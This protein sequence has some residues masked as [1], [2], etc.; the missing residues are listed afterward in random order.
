MKQRDEA[1]RL[2]VV[3]SEKAQ[4]AMYDSGKMKADRDQLE[5]QLQNAIQ[6]EKLLQDR[7]DF[8]KEKVDT[9][10][11]SIKNLHAESGHFREYHEELCSKYEKQDEKHYKEI[12]SLEEEIQTLR[13]TIQNLKTHTSPSSQSSEK[14]DAFIAP[15]VPES[16]AS[17]EEAAQDDSVSRVT[18]SIVFK[19]KTPNRLGYM[20][21]PRKLTFSTPFKIEQFK[22]KATQSSSSSDDRGNTKTSGGALL[23]RLADEVGSD[24]SEPNN[25]VPAGTRKRAY[26]LM[27][28]P[29]PAYDEKQTLSGP[30]HPADNEDDMGPN[31]NLFGNSSRTK[32]ALGN[33]DREEDWTAED[34]RAAIAHLYEMAKGI[35]FNLHK[36]SIG[37]NVPDELLHIQEPEIW[38]LLNSLV[39][40]DR[41]EAAAH[42]RFL[43]MTEQY[44]PYV[45]Q[46]VMLDYIF[47]TIMT[48][49][50][51]LGFS[52]DMDKQL[53]ALQS[54]IVT[55]ANVNQRSSN[56]SRQRTIEEHAQ[57]I[58]S[59][60][61]QKD[62]RK[63]RSSLVD[64]HA[65]VLTNVLTPLQNS[66]VPDEMALKA[67]RILIRG[68]YN[69]S[70]R[71]WSSGMTL[72]YF[73]PETG[74]KFLVATMEAKNGSVL[75]SSAE[76]LQ[77]SQYRISLVIGPTLTL[78]DDRESSLLRTYGIRKA[79]V[80]VMK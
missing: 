35:V 64:H 32:N 34:V 23:H 27:P 15:S 29:F 71:I 50:I 1:I 43:L 72:H 10:K 22:D 26:S 51:F 4:H 45:I 37:P 41:P 39:Y 44:R 73:F 58:K 47:K 24:S 66:T 25:Q 59:I 55:F 11:E 17:V 61:D 67:M 78:R 49:D 57:L 60:G 53:R 54:Q 8:S 63:F 16:T 12:R 42:T 75:G 19:G 21:N 3:D 79:Q 2:R 14:A 70:M 20:S 80:L 38:S 28:S 5:H 62:S 30:A 69:I 36:A 7:V 18:D 76:H 9:L 65:R 46:R 31:S 68:A 56:I 33:P 40:P 52:P 77:F 13:Q 48:P 6:R 74:S